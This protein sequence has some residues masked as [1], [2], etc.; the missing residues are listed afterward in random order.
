MQ[1]G[2]ALIARR[3]SLSWDCFTLACHVFHHYHVIYWM[4]ITLYIDRFYGHGDPQCVSM[5]PGF[6]R[7]ATERESY[8]QVLFKLVSHEVLFFLRTHLSTYSASSRC[9]LT[10]W[11]Y[12]L[13]AETDKPLP[14]VA[15][16]G[17]FYPYLLYQHHIFVYDL[18]WQGQRDYGRVGWV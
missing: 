12:S 15:S 3:L 17:W 14:S 5:T 13:Y 8:S 18:G 11:N 1:S 16:S 9:I 2:S 6:A 7:N 10:M 4:L